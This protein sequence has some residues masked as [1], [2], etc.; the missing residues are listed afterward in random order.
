MLQQNP[1]SHNE[2]LVRKLFGAAI[3]RKCCRE[4]EA[5]SLIFLQS[6]KKRRS[7]PNNTLYKTQSK[8]ANQRKMRSEANSAAPLPV[9]YRKVSFR[10]GCFPVKI[11]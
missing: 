5:S 7:N 3:S 11:K 10:I 6:K 4:F 1:I 2:A 9:C 8:Q